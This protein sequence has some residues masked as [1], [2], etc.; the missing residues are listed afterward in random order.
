MQVVPVTY[1]QP[2][3]ERNRRAL[4]FDMYSEATRRS[5]MDEAERSV[6]P[7]ASGPVVLEQEGD[8][9]SP[10]FLIYM[11]VFDQIEGGRRL[12][13][14]IY[15]P[16]NARDFLSS[17]M[18]LESRTAMGIRLYDGKVMPGE[19]PMGRRHFWF[20]VVPV[21]ETDEGTDRWALEQGYI[22]ITPLRL[23]LTDEQ[24]LAAMQAKHPL[25]APRPTPR[26][27]TGRS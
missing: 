19:D 6:R 15:S 14:F 2:D 9:P 21:T 26:T 18:L 23:D 10:G 8:R 3:T 7:T 27:G 4:G 12:K 17:A 24:K 1:L 16:F 25:P 13:G 20:T 5:A 22:S 11:P